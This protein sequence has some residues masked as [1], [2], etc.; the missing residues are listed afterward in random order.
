MTARLPLKRKLEVNDNKDPRREGRE[1]REERDYFQEAVKAGANYMRFPNEA[2]LQTVVECMQKVNLV[3]L[4]L[5]PLEDPAESTSA[6]LA[7]ITWPVRLNY[8]LARL[9]QP[10]TL[11]VPWNAQFPF[12]LNLLERFWPQHV[13][14]FTI[15][16]HLHDRFTEELDIRKLLPILRHPNI[17]HFD[18]LCSLWL[19]LPPTLGD[20][21]PL[22]NITSF[23]ESGAA[24][25]R[26]E[27][28]A[29]WFP[30][31]EWVPMHMT[32]SFNYDTV[33]EAEDMTLFPMIKYA[34]A[35]V[36]HPNLQLLMLDS[37]VDANFLNY[38]RI[39][40]SRLQTLDVYNI[41]TLNLT[42]EVLD[43]V[44]HLPHLSFLSLGH[45]VHYLKAFGEEF[46]TKR[47]R[48]LQKLREPGTLQTVRHLRIRNLHAEYF[49]FLEFVGKPPSPNLVLLTWGSR[50]VQVAFENR[51]HLLPIHIQ[52]HTIK[53]PGNPELRHKNSRAHHRQWCCI[54]FLIVWNR[55]NQMSPLCVSGLT[56]VRHF[57]LKLD[58]DFQMPL[59]IRGDG[60]RFS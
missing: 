50:L 48:V 40:N 44:P 10:E 13:K 37:Y 17:T 21:S 38:Y 14:C 60:Y 57:F 52:Y 31:L 39:H 56:V 26:K 32:S 58:T 23:W 6:V 29:K 45:D 59:L 30:N 34:H 3:E 55:A 24:R 35:K 1:G 22:D 28:L 36:R 46:E 15:C 54:A 4:P 9:S 19:H 16:T 49:E 47:K 25:Q 51:H 5:C 2:D 11:R 18:N 42:L 27:A 41:F 43:L 20:E 12:L 53:I 8:P 7:M 33:E